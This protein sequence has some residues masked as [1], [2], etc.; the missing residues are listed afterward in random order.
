M[1]GNVDGVVSITS[2]ELRVP[3]V[4]GNVDGVASH[5]FVDMHAVMQPYTVALVLGNNNRVS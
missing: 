2:Y 5:V 3:F 4:Y 1:S